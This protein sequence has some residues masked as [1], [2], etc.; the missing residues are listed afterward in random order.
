MGAVPSQA[1]CK[2]TRRRAQSGPSNDGAKAVV[3]GLP[4][5]TSVLIPHDTS[6]DPKAVMERGG[7]QVEWGKVGKA[8]KVNKFLRQ[9]LPHVVDA[10][11]MLPTLYL[12][13]LD[14]IFRVKPGE[15]DAGLRAGNDSSEVQLVVPEKYS[16]FTVEAPSDQALTQQ[17]RT[18]MAYLKRHAQVTT[19]KVTRWGHHYEMD[20]NAE[21]W[22]FSLAAARPKAGINL[23]K[24]AFGIPGEAEIYLFA[25]NHASAAFLSEEQ[26]AAFEN[27]ILELPEHG[28]EWK[29]F[30]IFLKMFFEGG[31]GYNFK[32]WL[33]DRSTYVPTQVGLAAL[34]VVPA[35]DG[36]C[37]ISTGYPY[38]V[39][40][41]FLSYADSVP[42]TIGAIRNLSPRHQ[43]YGMCF[44]GC[45]FTWAPDD[46]EQATCLGRQ[47][48]SV[49]NYSS[50]LPHGGFFYVPRTLAEFHELGGFVYAFGEDRR[51]LEKPC[52]MMSCEQGGEEEDMG[53]A[54]SHQPSQV[55]IKCLEGEPSNAAL[56]CGHRLCCTACSQAGGF[57]GQPCPVCQ[58][59]VETMRRA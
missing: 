29:A 4:L 39:R 53:A 45:V 26:M 13:F 11:L 19:G 34:G 10:R 18:V 40:P 46:G 6:E 17:L 33:P 23:D 15:M 24:A 21:S 55:C 36:Q 38:L 59:P 52:N 48:S 20:A 47:S 32:D 22:Y 1:V 54:V 7:I 50:V 16:S 5:V 27:C 12:H 28:S 51:D 58:R 2:C 56:P 49:L 30:S 3:G 14:P 8:A 37:G 44:T 57:V 25:Q 31:F 42:V 41:E 9:S 43:R 35:F